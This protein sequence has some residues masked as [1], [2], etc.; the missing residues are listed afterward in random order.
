MDNRHAGDGCPFLSARALTQ[1]KQ[2][3]GVIEL[4]PADLIN[5]TQTTRLATPTFASNGSNA[6]DQDCPTCNGS[7]WDEAKEPREIC[8]CVMR[9]L[10]E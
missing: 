7:G 4:S 3:G 1:I 8:D 5:V 9:S 2:K 10:E 6:A